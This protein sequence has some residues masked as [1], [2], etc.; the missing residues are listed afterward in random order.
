MTNGEIGV[1]ET[2]L[3]QV[4]TRYLC[5]SMKPR[6][7]VTEMLDGRLLPVSMIPPIQGSCRILVSIV[8]GGDSS[9]QMNPRY[10][11]RQHQ[12]FTTSKQ[13]MRYEQQHRARPYSQQAL[14]PER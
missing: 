6:K 14:V 7:T 1:G 5:P 11:S 10:P 12:E 13:R 9:D 4:G 2:T 8:V 3:Q